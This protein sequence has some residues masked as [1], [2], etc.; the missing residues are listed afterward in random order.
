MKKISMLSLVVIILLLAACRQPNPEPELPPTD[1]EQASTAL[2]TDTSI[3][4][5]TQTALPTVITQP[6]LDPTSTSAPLPPGTPTVDLKPL[7]SGSPIPLLPESHELTIH[8]VEMLTDRYGWAITRVDAGIDHILTTKD[9]GVS[10]QDVSPPQPELAE[11]E[12]LFVSAGFADQNTAFVH[13][14]GSE[15]IW[16]TRDG[17]ITWT[18][19]AVTFASRLGALFTV[20]DS[21][22]A[23]L[24]QFLEGG[25]QKVYTAV[26]RTADGGQTWETI[27]DPYTDASIQ[28]FDKTGVLF[29]SPQEGLLTRDFRGVA[30]Y[31]DLSLT[32][33]GGA[34]WEDLSIPGPDQ[35]PKII[36]NTSCAC[37]LYNPAAETLEKITAR[38]SCSCFEEDGKVTRNFLYQTTDG[39]TSWSTSPMPNGELYQAAGGVFYAVTREIN[40]SD[41]AGKTWD[42]VKSV[43]WDGEFS[44]INQNLAWAVAHDPTDEEY[45]LV[46]TT[47][48][49]SSF[50][51]IRP[52]ML[53]SPSQR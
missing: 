28:S 26:A 2:P 43:N 53:S 5:P 15:L 23:W 50:E 34:T 40:R 17:G 21:Q 11:R 35:A 4:Q 32:S 7:L 18:P 44:F 33:D 46:K 12:T 52:T 25:M 20:L 8:Q 41:N 30:A 22:H 24:F 27:L 38:L 29:V 45:A 51:I 9:G 49:C 31:V 39:G 37:G 14:H 6:T 42:L 19:A 47:D 3:P 13:Y 16:T 48:G 1:T 36:E 10:W